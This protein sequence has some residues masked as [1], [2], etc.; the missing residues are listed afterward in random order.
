MIWYPASIAAGYM[1]C[2]AVAGAKFARKA[3]CRVAVADALFG[4]LFY[5]LL[6]GL[7]LDASLRLNGS[8][9]DRWTAVSASSAMLGKLLAA[10]MA[11]HIPMLFMR[12]TD[13]SN[14]PLYV[15]HHLVVIL[16]YGAG[17]VRAKAHFW[18]ALSALC[19]VT[20]VFLTVEEL[21]A[22]VWAK[23]T[24]RLRTFIQVGFTASYVLLRLALFPLSLAW[25]FADFATMPR[26]QRQL[27][28]IF[29][30]GLYPLANIAVFAL[31][32]CW[33]GKIITRIRATLR[34]WS[35]KLRSL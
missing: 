35:T 5:P 20:N 12:N 34:T 13:P 24:S 8:M 28:G 3:P 19:E 31:S 25:F 10:R 32:V 16:V 18:G 27:F 14:R 6:V 15:V 2:Y 22:L 1:S 7:A 33:A 9:V 30:L 17:T 21:F 26:D 11:V 4:I 23:S 29:E